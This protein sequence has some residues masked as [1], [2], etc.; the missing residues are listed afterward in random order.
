MNVG[1]RNGDVPGNVR[2]NRARCAGQLGFPA[3]ALLTARQVHG[4]LCLAVDSHWTPESMPEADGLAT[5]R[6]DVLLGVVTAD[7]APVLLAD[8]EAGVV[9]ACHAGWRGALDGIVE[10]TLD[11]MCSLGAAPDRTVA[12]VGP[13]IAQASYEVGEEFRDRFV[14]A[15]P[16]YARFF[17]QPTGDPRPLFDL[18]GFVSARLQASGVRQVEVLGHDTCAD[19]DRFFSFRRKTLTGEPAFGLQL[20]AIGLRAGA[21]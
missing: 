21:D 14:A 19:P 1:V 20:S 8:G 2:A 3:Q 15:D 18:K 6:S 9:G 5:R 13:C 4:T 11:R 7:C 16:A 12:A 17:R 10:A